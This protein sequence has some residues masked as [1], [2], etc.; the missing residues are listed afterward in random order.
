MARSERGCKHEAL[1][2][3]PDGAVSRSRGLFR[4][5]IAGFVAS[6]ASRA[7]RRRVESQPG[8]REQSR[9][10]SHREWRLEIRSSWRLCSLWAAPG[11]RLALLAGRKAA[12]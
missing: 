1:R 3:A 6:Q 5:E 2:M 10:I 11:F 12:R 4:A 7:Y 9:G 8:P